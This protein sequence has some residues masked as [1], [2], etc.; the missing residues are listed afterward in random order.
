MYL[1]FKVKIP[2]IRSKIFPRTI[3]GTT[4]INY[5]YDR[6]YKQE[7]KYNI[8]KRNTIGKRCEDDIEM[9]YP[10]ANY[11]KYFPDAELPKRDERTDRSSCL[12]V[13]ASIVIRKIIEEYKIDEMI[14]RIIGHDS[15]LFLDLVS[16]SIITENNAGQYY[17]D[18]AY[19]HPLLT[20][21]MKIYRFILIFEYLLLTRL[22][23]CDTIYSNKR[24]L[25]E[26]L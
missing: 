4:Y 25:G 16:Y 21:G 20:K 17:P 7:K 2:D 15:G 9:M 19:N 10:N 6:V 24:M 26:E 12:R 3:K 11:F 8:P 18:Y 5:E 1:D 22:F 13:G 23:F 14:K